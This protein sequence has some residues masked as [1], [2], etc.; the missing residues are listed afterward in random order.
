LSCF[1]YVR[2]G[3]RQRPWDDCVYSEDGSINSDDSGNYPDDVK[4]VR[5]LIAAVRESSARHN[6]T[7]RNWHLLQDYLDENTLAEVGDLEPPLNTTRNVEKV[8]EREK[9]ISR[10]FAKAGSKLIFSS[11]L[12]MILLKI[13]T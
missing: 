7:E 13:K 2:A 8:K 3:T 10:A 1:R 6:N 4:K 5:D 11:I 12:T 9:A